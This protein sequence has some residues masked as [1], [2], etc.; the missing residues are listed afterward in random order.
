MLLIGKR[1]FD[2]FEFEV[3]SKYRYSSDLG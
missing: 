1:G 2:S 3:F